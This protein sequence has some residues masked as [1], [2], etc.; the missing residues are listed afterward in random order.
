MKLRSGAAV[1][2]LVYDRDADEIAD[3]HAVRSYMGEDR[4]NGGQP[5]GS[6]MMP[7]HAGAQ[8]RRCMR[9]RL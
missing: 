2:V 4:P 9:E 8:I 1:H 6:S 5:R 3:R 7:E